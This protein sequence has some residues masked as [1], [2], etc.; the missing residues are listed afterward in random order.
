VFLCHW[1]SKMDVASSMQLVMDTVTE[2]HFLPAS[3][4]GEPPGAT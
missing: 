1:V 4:V 3:E 2:E